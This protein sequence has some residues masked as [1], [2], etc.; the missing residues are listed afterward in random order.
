MKMQ[1]SMK[2]TGSS[3]RDNNEVAGIIRITWFL[4]GGSC[5]GLPDTDYSTFELFSEAGREASD[6]PCGQVGV[7]E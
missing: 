7:V 2:W 3:R 4:V 5:N 1:A 6:R